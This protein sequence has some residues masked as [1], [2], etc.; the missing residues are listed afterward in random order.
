MSD[1]GIASDQVRALAEAV[2]DLL[3][4]RGLLPRVDE[5]AP[6]VLKVGEVARLLGRAPGWVY[7]HAGELGAFKFG[8]G[9]RARLGFDV[10]TIERWKRER[11]LRPPS[12]ERSRRLSRGRR[13]A[14]VDVEL[15]PY[16]PAPYRA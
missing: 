13:P 10:A 5:P 12:A 7:E 16:E 1:A 9:P 2:V 6:Q 3:E 14:S 11:Q 4:E 8:T 15:I